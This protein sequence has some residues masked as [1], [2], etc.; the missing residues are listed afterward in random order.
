MSQ[1]L[2]NIFVKD[3]TRLGSSLTWHKP[4]RG[5][6]AGEG[7][8]DEVAPAFLGLPEDRADAR[9]VDEVLGR[10]DQ[11][12]GGARLRGLGIV[13][14]HRISSGVQEADGPPK[15]AAPRS[16]ARARRRTAISWVSMGARSS[17]TR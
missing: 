16:R 11:A 2:V 12:A 9:R 10:L 5:H 6:R 15:G 3:Y 1:R 14:M 13:A 17:T 4:G 7:L 8:A